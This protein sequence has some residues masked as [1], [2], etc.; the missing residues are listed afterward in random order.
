MVK[1]I[2]NITNMF[3]DAILSHLRYV[4]EAKQF[5][6]A[7]NTQIYKENSYITWK[8]SG[9]SNFVKA[10]FTYIRNDQDI[11]PKSELKINNKIKCLFNVNILVSN[12]PQK[13][14]FKRM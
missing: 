3:C 7:S 10:Y 2:K 8:S 11:F 1:T 9:L 14:W 13:K 12:I 4:S 5:T 6:K